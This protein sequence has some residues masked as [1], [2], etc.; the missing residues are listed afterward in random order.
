MHPE[1]ISEISQRRKDKYQ[2]ISPLYEILNT[3]QMN[4]PK[5]H[6]QPHKILKYKELLVARGQMCGGNE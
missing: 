4:I 2:L 6:P 1:G 5:K 3:K